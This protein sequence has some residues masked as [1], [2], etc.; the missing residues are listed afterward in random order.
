[1]ESNG[2]V[3]VLEGRNATF[4]C[5]IASEPTHITHWLHN[6]RFLTS[7][8]KHIITGNGTIHG[9]LTITHAQYTDAGEYTCVGV[10]IHGEINATG[11]LYVQGM[12]V[13][14]EF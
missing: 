13:F 4:A 5:H 10:N 12:K 3:N 14:D 7:N 8:Q 9:T 2:T 1:M 6:D 11:I